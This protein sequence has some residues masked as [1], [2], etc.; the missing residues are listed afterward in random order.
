MYI[1]LPLFLFSRV[2]D[3]NGGKPPITFATFQETVNSMGIP[4]RP[5][6]K[7]DFRKVKL[8][9]LPNAQSLYGLKPYEELGET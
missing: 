3:E 1:S 7:P 5:T 2:I 6:E 9:V 8:R 4:E